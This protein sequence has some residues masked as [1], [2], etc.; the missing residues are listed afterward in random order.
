MLEICDGMIAYFCLI[1]KDPQNVK[2]M[3][4]YCIVGLF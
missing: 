2:K 3:M 4:L 1:F